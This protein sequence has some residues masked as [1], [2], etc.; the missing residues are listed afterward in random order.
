M[1]KNKTKFPIP[2]CPQLASKNTYRD[3]FIRNEWPQ[4]KNK[5]PL[6]RIA[7]LVHDC[8]TITKRI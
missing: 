4:S 3:I 6:Q 1:E 8:Q 7:N 5:L 2:A